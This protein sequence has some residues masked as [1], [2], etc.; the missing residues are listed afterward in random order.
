[1]DSEKLE[2]L[3][4]KAR[5]LEQRSHNNQDLK[6]VLLEN[7]KNKDLQIA[8][9]TGVLTQIQDNLNS[10]NRELDYHRLEDAQGL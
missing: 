4:Q 8:N 7:G 6:T 2:E 5:V 10:L 9:M 1:M 3:E